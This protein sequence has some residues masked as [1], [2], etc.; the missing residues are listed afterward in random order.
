MLK[1]GFLGTEMPDGCLKFLS[2]CVF[3]SLYL[4]FLCGGGGDRC[5][6]PGGARQK[7]ELVIECI[8]IPSSYFYFIFQILMIYL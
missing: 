2:L 4:V 5:L 3:V 8:Y 1:T 6:T 7:E